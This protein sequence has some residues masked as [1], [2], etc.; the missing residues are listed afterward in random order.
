MA[1]P[2]AAAPALLLLIATPL[3][4]RRSKP[5]SPGMMAHGTKVPHPHLARRRSR[6]YPGSAGLEGDDRDRARG[7]LLDDPRVALVEVRR[8]HPSRSSPPPRRETP[9]APDPAAD[10]GA[11]APAPAVTEPGEPRTPVRVRPP[12]DTDRPVRA[13]PRRG[14]SC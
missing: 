1:P 5:P 9:S 3:H 7:A 2:P 13:D 6:V 14:V 10:V 12:G 8:A 11:G 4:R